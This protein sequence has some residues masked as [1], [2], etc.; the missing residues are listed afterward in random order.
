MSLRNLIQKN[1]PNFTYITPILTA[2]QYLI[3][4]VIQN[5]NIRWLCHFT[6]R[7]NLENIKLFGLKPKHLLAFNEAITTDSVRCDRHRDAICLSISKP[8]KWMFQ[9]KQNQ[10]MDLCLILISPRVLY[11]KNCVF[12]PHNAATASYRDISDN[13]LKGGQALERM[14]DNSVHFQRSGKA[15]SNI[16]RNLGLL[17][18]ETTS[19]QAEVQCLDIIEPEYINHIFDESIPLEYKDIES[20]ISSKSRIAHLAE[21]ARKQ[22]EVEKA[23]LAEE[24]LRREEIEQILL[25]EEA[26]KQAKVEKARLAEESRKLEHAVSQEKPATKMSSPPTS[27]SG[28]DNSCLGIIILIILIWIFIL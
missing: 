8:N 14:F 18:C 1:Y 15:P 3:H 28:G 25:A 21:E 2:E 10:G 13:E 11:E 19:D 26:R 24:A 22:A 4:S 27:S 23:R 16:Y 6:P 9:M 5:R 20:V 7:Q 12:Y 17:N